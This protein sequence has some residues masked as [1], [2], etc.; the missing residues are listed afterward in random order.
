MTIKAAVV[1]SGLAGSLLFACAAPTED[2]PSEATTSDLEQEVGDVVQADL[3]SVVEEL[4]APAAGEARTLAAPSGPL[5]IWMSPEGR[6]SNDGSQ[7]RP[8]KSIAGV[9]EHLLGLYPKGKALD[10]DVEVRIAPGTYSGDEVTWT[11][12]SAGHSITFMPA[13]FRVGMRYAKV[14]ALGGRPVFDGTR[15]CKANKAGAA[16]KF[17][18]V[19]QPKGAGASRLRFYYLEIRDWATT[20][21][22]LHNS[23]EGRNLVYGCRFDNIGTYRAAYHELLHGMAAV[24]LS[25]SDHNVI[26]NNSFVNIKNQ[27]GE[28]RFLHAVYMNVHSDENRVE[29]NLTSKVSGDPIKVR[30][31]SNRNVVTNNTLRCSGLKSFFLD[32]PEPFG[33]NTGRAPECDSYRNVFKGNHLDCGYFGGSIAQTFAEPGK[34]CGAPASW[35]RFVVSGNTVA[36][37]SSC[38]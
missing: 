33:G 37:K 27:S 17:F 31:Y 26:L 14:K 24:G 10:A 35:Q 1:V 20:G 36:C 8:L 12:P 3:A 15:A 28:E 5:T 30:Q 11:L 4:D 16:C 23:G 25:D 18:N 32:Y 7:A 29:G 19:D 13:G 2:D 9:H 34:A 21:I 22:G 6:D 38:N